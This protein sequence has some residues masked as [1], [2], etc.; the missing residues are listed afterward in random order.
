M[1]KIT[2]LKF[3]HQYYEP[4]KKTTEMLEL[5]AIGKARNERDERKE[6]DKLREEKEHME[7]IIR[8]I[9]IEAM[10]LSDEVKLFER[11]LYA[12]KT[13]EQV[14]A[15]ITKQPDLYEI[16]RMNET[17]VTTRHLL[18]LKQ[19]E[20]R[21]L[22]ESLHAQMPMIPLPITQK[23]INFINKEIERRAEEDLELDS[24]RFLET[25]FYNDEGHWQRCYSGV[26]FT[27]L[28][29]KGAKRQTNTRRKTRRRI[30]AEVN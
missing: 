10:R 9:P 26:L 22:E 14:Q 5:L 20:I 19:Q 7:E 13:E 4:H 16:A 23:H 6:I 12:L 28:V 15:F 30:T 24:Y 8:N 21:Q 29:N 1:K 18:D 25:E 27:W 17:Y 11:E 3:P 2:L